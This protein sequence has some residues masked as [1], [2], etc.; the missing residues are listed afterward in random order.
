MANREE[1]KRAWSEFSPAFASIMYPELV[2]G[3]LAEQLAAEEAEKQ[4]W[5]DFSFAF[6]SLMYP[7][8][9]EGTTDDAADV[10]ALDAEKREWAEFSFAFASLFWP[11]E[12]VQEKAAVVQEKAADE[13]LAWSEFSFA[14]A[15]LMWPELVEGAEEVPERKRFGL[16]L[17][18]IL[19]K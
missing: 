5:S 14:F 17:P 16:T 7:E 9:V 3:T 1:E 10:P 13:K 2:E 6:A 4:E 11:E 15:A 18:G 12:L 19:S 8:L